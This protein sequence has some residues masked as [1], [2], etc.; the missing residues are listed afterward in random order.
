MTVVLDTQ[1]LVG[2]VTT[3]YRILPLDVNDLPGSD[4]Q[5]HSYGHQTNIVFNPNSGGAGQ[6]VYY[7][8]LSPATPTFRM[9]ITN[10]YNGGNPQT[11]IFDSDDY[12]ASGIRYS[13]NENA[14]TAKI[15][16][17]MQGNYTGTYVSE[18]Q[19]L[20][21]NLSDISPIPL[22]TRRRS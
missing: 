11:Y 21:L 19:I 8:P 15:S 1:N 7:D 4:D 16:I 20:P 18:F 10:I 9:S 3:T 17:P 12:D 13:D 22:C 14:G 6:P 2:T 5:G